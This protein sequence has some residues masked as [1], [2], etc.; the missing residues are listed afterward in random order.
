MRDQKWHL[1]T[2]SSDGISTIY[3]Y[4]DSILEV[5][6]PVDNNSFLFR[7]IGQAYT[8]ST[9]IGGHF[10]GHIDEL[11]IYSSQLGQSEI[12]EIYNS[13]IKSMLANQAV[14]NTNN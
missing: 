1:I 5:T 9:S 12:K 7:N 3:I 11:Q 10:R 4:V 13:G 2:W 6:I 14:F 8:S